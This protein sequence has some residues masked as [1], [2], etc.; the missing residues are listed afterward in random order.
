MIESDGPKRSP[1]ESLQLEDCTSATAAVKLQDSCVEVESENRSGCSVS[2]EL[3]VS[4]ETINEYVFTSPCFQ[5]K[6]S[7]PDRMMPPTPSVST[8]VSC[9]LYV[10]VPT[11]AI[12]AEAPGACRFTPLDRNSSHV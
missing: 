3:L 9:R 1:P 10:S 7:L 4:S 6:L 2:N 12:E 8:P 5:T 11:S